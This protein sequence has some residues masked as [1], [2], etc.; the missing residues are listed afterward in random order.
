MMVR[1]IAGAPGQLHRFDAVAERGIIG[2]GQQP[3]QIVQE[4][5]RV[6]ITT[7]RKPVLVHG[8]ADSSL[9]IK[10]HRNPVVTFGK[11]GLNPQQLV[12]LRD[13][14]IHFPGFQQRVTHAEIG[15]SVACGHRECVPPDGFAGPPVTQLQAGNHKA[16]GQRDRGRNRQPRS[17]VTP[18]PG[19][20]FPGPNDH[21]KQPDERNVRITIRQRLHP[22]LHQADHRDQRAQEPQPPDG[23]DRTAPRPPQHRE[24]DGGQQC[25]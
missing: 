8:L 17:R 16:R 3:R 9:L 25:A 5:G 6:G 13:A 24:R 12:Q 1:Q 18:P 15:R 20:A 10:R 22:H 19:Q 14:L 11:V 23:Q 2:R 4:N 7:Q 21:D